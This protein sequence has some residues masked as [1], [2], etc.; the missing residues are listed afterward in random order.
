MTTENKELNFEGTKEELFDRFFCVNAYDRQ[1]YPQ[2]KEI[3]NCLMVRTRPCALLNKNN[4]IALS[5][6]FKMGN[7]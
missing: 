6:F 7:E 4:D 3:N 2:F 5:L 1:F